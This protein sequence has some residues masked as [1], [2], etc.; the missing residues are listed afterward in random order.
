[1]SRLE[2]PVEP[3]DLPT[4]ALSSGD[5]GATVIVRDL[6][7]RYPG[8]PVN[9]VDGI[10]FEVAPGEV[11]GF[12]GPNGAG[13]TTT[14]AILTTRARPSAGTALIAGVDVARHPVDARRLLA[15]VPQR[16]NLDL[17]LTARRNLLFHAAYF[18]VPPA[19]RTARADFLLGE[20][21]LADRAHDKVDRFSGG[22]AQRLMIARALM[23]DPRV[24][25]LDEPTTGLDPQARLFVWDRIRT[26]RADGVTVVLTT[27]DMEEAALLADRVAIMDHGKLLALETP[28]ALTA[29]VPGRGTV[30]LTVGGGGGAQRL[31]DVLGHLHDVER[32][33]VVAGTE[34]DTDSGR[35]GE[36]WGPAL[37][38]DGAPGATPRGEGSHDRYLGG[39]D[40]A[41]GHVVVTRLRLYCSVEA[42]TL[43]GPVAEAVLG[44][45]GSLMEVHLGSPSLEDVF[46]HLTG[47]SLRG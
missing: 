17:S 42:A 8:R 36:S 22:Q 10:S 33:E 30:T 24:L 2:R 1:M 18:G 14:V 28:R 12:L 26:L 7:K 29:L 15:V 31:V 23:H 38:P 34:E 19:I 45:G 27:H 37:T 43:V 39:L 44:A 20:L 35:G 21:G 46:I 41:D 3:A 6:T 4:P 5:R 11:F 47:R 9:A 16:M 25:F 13:K 40:R 32:V